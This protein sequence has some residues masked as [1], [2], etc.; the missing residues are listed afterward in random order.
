MTREEHHLDQAG[1]PGYG[2][3]VPQPDS[4]APHD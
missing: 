1:R 3:R 4:P 2:R